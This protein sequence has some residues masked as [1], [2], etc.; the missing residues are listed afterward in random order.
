MGGQGG[1]AEVVVRTST[2]SFLPITESPGQLPAKF[3]KIETCEHSYVKFPPSGW[4]SQ[5]NGEGGGKKKRGE[6]GERVREGGR[7]V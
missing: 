6:G 5:G 3:S 2:K 7:L 1:Q 4:N